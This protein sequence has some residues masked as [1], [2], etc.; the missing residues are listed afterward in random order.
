V[1]LV[2]LGSEAVGGDGAGGVAV[3]AQ[4]F[5]DGGAEQ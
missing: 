1:A 4:G 5:G 2:D 3:Q